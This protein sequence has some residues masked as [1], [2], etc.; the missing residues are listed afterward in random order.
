MLKRYQPWA[1]ALK[2][3]IIFKIFVN[4]LIHKKCAGSRWN[5]SR[6]CVFYLLSWS[7]SSCRTLS[8]TVI[9]TETSNTSLTKECFFLC[10][11]CISHLKLRAAWGLFAFWET[12]QV[13]IRRGKLMQSMKDDTNMTDKHI[14][15]C[16]NTPVHWLFYKLSNVSDPTNFDHLISI[17]LWSKI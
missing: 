6:N 9:P 2:I 7:S 8:D 5:E 11:D 16:G 15:R 10:L 12:D 4:V 13:L 1:T 3:I 14:C 17:C